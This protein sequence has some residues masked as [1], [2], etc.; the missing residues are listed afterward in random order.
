MIRNLAIFFVIVLIKTSSCYADILV[1]EIN[2]MGS[3]DSQFAEWIELYNNSDEEVNLSGWKLYEAGGDTLVFT[4]TKKIAG[5]SYLLLER[6]TTS[7]PD[8]VPSV[9]DELGSFG[10]SG[11]SNSGEFLVLK[12]NANNTVQSLNFSPGWP[13]GDSESKKT[14]QWD[15]SKWIT[16]SPTPKAGLTS[17]T[18]TPEEPTTS[19]GGSFV[20]EKFEPKVTLSLP[21]VIYTDIVYEYKAETYLEYGLVY[22]GVFVWNM[23]DGTIYKSQ[24]PEIVKHRYKYPGSYMVSFGYYRNPYEKKPVLFTKEKRLVEN[25][26]LVFKVLPDKGF[27][28]TNNTSDDFDVSLWIIKLSDNNTLTLPELSLIAPKS[29]IIIP[30]SN[31]GLSSYLGEATLLTPEWLAFG[32][33]QTE[34][35]KYTSVK[36]D[37]KKSP[38]QTGEV[39]GESAFGENIIKEELKQEGEKP[40]KNNKDYTRI[41]ILSIALVIV[42]F[43]FV[44]LEKFIGSKEE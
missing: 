13:A 14:M 40:I 30:F 16:S 18:I 25:S 31:F 19:G 20:P 28:I 29:T 42:I 1:T 21:K 33:D 10:G 39:L 4:F 8:P 7:S 44:L 24:N 37:N 11:F 12:D 35:I 5:K 34:P 17:T 15:G 27:E 26:K 43:L 3:T 9:N 6:T 22:N 23:G 32:A 36:V 41:I 2:W 38:S